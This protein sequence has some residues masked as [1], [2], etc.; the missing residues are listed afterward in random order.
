MTGVRLQQDG[1]KPITY[2][3]LR[4]NYVQERMAQQMAKGFN[5]EQ[6][7]LVVSKEVGHERIDVIAVYQAGRKVTYI[8]N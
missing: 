3:G 8:F 6:A 5:E 2:H 7:A 4:Y 1:A